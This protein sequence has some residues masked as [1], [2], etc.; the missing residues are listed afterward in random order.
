MV[1]AAGKAQALE[2]VRQENYRL[3]QEKVRSLANRTMLI[4]ATR[5]CLR[6]T[7][8]TGQGGGGKEADGA[9][10]R[11]DAKADAANERR[12]GG[13]HRALEKECKK[14]TGWPQPNCCAEVF[15]GSGRTE[16]LSVGHGQCGDTGAAKHYALPAVGKAQQIPAAANYLA[17]RPTL[18]QGTSTLSIFLSIFIQT[19]INL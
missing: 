12:E 18:L 4:V 1:S 10:N 15:G 17:E 5:L 6:L 13:Q 7:R 19:S 14:R 9:R 11:G 3:A 16:L 8:T 2:E